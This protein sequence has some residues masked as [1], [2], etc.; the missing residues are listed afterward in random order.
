[1]GI[2]IVINFDR[3]EN[4]KIVN[5][6]IVNIKIVNIKIVYVNEDRIFTRSQDS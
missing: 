4:I 5:I 3:R 1:M 6:K 2:T